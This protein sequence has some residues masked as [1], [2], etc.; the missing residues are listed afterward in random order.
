M[1]DEGGR[2]KEQKAEGTKQYAKILT[3]YRFLPSA[4]SLFHPSALS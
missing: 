3:A 4:F 2:M 1:K